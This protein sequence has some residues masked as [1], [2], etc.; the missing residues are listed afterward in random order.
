VP[1]TPKVLFDTFAEARKRFKSAAEKFGDY[2]SPFELLG[3]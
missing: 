1:D 2:I 3:K